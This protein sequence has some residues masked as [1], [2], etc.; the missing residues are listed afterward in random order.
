V[1]YLPG[2]HRYL[3]FK[4]DTA[5]IFGPFR[6]HSSA[7]LPPC[8]RHLVL[9]IA[10]DYPRVY[11]FEFDHDDMFVLRIHRLSNWEHDDLGWFSRLV[12]EHPHVERITV[13][14]R[15]GILRLPYRLFTNIQHRVAMDNLDVTVVGCPDDPG[16]AA[17]VREKA[18]IP[19][20]QDWRSTMEE[21]RGGWGFSNRRPE[22]LEAAACLP[23]D[24][25]DPKAERVRAVTLDKW[26]DEVGERLFRLATEE[27][28]VAA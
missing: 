2:V 27:D 11:K 24:T 14:F 19:M 10:N 22:E 28:Y 9:S 8:V 1:R 15:E 20:A 7:I 13:V 5:I 25:F 26:R 17:E 12:K 18:A 3:G 16:Y 6:P 21:G 4:A 23:L